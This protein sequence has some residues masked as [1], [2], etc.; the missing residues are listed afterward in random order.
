M[1]E[2][3]GR[4]YQETILILP[5]GDEGRINISDM[6]WVENNYTAEGVGQS[7]RERAMALGVPMAMEINRGPF[8]GID[9]KWY[10]TDK[11]AIS[12]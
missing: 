8:G 5:E 12:E 2:H 7:V 6:A 3:N 11:E 1:P 9:I 10:R 4:G